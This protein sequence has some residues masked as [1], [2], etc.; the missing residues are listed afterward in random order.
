VPP[1]SIRVPA[2]PKKLR[3]LIFIASRFEDGKNNSLN[4]NKVRNFYANLVD[5]TTGMTQAVLG[6][7][8]ILYNYLKLNHKTLMA[9]GQEPFCSYFISILS[10]PP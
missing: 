3:R 10:G 8:V 5:Q 1:T 2:T 7:K 4:N 6:K 9:L